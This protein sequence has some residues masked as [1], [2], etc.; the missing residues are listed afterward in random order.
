M[1]QVV[2]GRK[3]SAKKRCFRAVKFDP[4]T[5]ILLSAEAIIK[6]LAN[7]MQMH[8]AQASNGCYNTEQI[9]LKLQ[10]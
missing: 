2:S 3:Y 1:C 9:T 7:M 8:Y 4:V 6:Q 10:V 5:E